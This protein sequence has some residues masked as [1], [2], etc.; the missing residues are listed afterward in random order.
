MEGQVYVC[1][2]KET[3]KG[4]SVWLKRRP[5]IKASG[6]TLADA[7][8]KLGELI[9]ARL[10]DGE[11]VREYVPP[12]ESGFGRDRLPI[13]LVAVFGEGQG[14][15]LNPEELFEGGLC[16]RCRMSQGTATQARR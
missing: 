8:E 3:S 9:T 13:R 12:I 16:P 4:I 14:I 5:Q 6:S 11:S 2:W 10:G 1:S 15:L 7:D